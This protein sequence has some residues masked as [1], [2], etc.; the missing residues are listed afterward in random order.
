MNFL[1]LM[2]KIEFF[3]RLKIYFKIFGSH[4]NQ[5]N[6]DDTQLLDLLLS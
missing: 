3:L 6:H 1:I 2:A 4:E 5:D